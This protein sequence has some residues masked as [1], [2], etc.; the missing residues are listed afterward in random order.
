M[1]H[2]PDH[3]LN[4]GTTLPAV[5]FGTFPHAA[6]DSAA[7]TEHALDLGYRL[8]DTALSYGNEAAVG[9]GMSR[10]PVPREEIVLTTKIPGRHHGH[11]GAWESVR[12]SLTNLGLERIDLLLIHWPLPRLGL[13]VE[14]WRAM[15]SMREEGLVRSIG[16]SNFTPAHI[17]RLQEETGVNPA[18]NQIEM[19]P[20]FPQRE[21]R[22]FHEEHGIITES[23]SPLGRGGA[24][25]QE[26]VLAE[27]A[28]THGVGAGQVVLRWH[29]QHGA[30]PIPASGN[31]ERQRANREL[32]F[33]LSAEE[34]AAIDALE[35]GRI[36]GQDPDEYEEF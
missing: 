27:I 22:A 7:L 26:P 28:R 35:Q 23:W 31:P 29:L 13:Y 15:I 24:L 5:G 21:Q 2:L 10:S 11:D 14:T 12:T 16:V 25:L 9:R 34:I 8:L 19:H 36:W 20:Y 17:R 32:E 30:V 6:V 4:D 3:R 18:V 33:E 1:T